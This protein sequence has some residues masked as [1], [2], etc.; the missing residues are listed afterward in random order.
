MDRD[1]KGTAHACAE[2]AKRQA[3]PLP[4][5]G[6]EATKHGAVGT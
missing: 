4:V 6:A 1:S 2:E 5:A 3:A